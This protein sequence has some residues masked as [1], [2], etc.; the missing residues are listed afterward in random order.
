MSKFSGKRRRRQSSGVAEQ[1]PPTPWP[2]PSQVPAAA[3]DP[4]LPTQRRAVTDPPTND[5]AGG[6]VAGTDPANE[7]HDVVPASLEPE[8]G[9]DSWDEWDES[10]LGERSDLDR[11]C[12]PPRMDQ[13]GD[14]VLMRRNRQDR[15]FDQEDDDV[16]GDERDDEPLIPL[17]STFRPLPVGA[18]RSH[19]AA[20]AAALPDS[21]TVEESPRRMVSR[22]YRLDPFIFDP[23]SIL[24]NRLGWYV[25]D[26]AVGAAP[27]FEALVFGVNGRPDVG[28][29]L[30]V[31]TSVGGWT[32]D[33]AVRELEEVRVRTL[34]DS[35]TAVG[36]DADG[37]TVCV[38]LRQHLD[39][40]AVRLTGSNQFAVAVEIADR[41]AQVIDD[42]L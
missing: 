33:S 40:Y 15:V 26:V 10:S 4:L 25:D 37:D 27:G 21:E 5:G 2:A 13:D 12:E 6:A 1:T 14:M 41:Y 24:V 9:W 11:V 19:G 38:S 42:E 30:I 22:P 18:A 28:I 34:G 23:S 31:P 7:R 32:F 8:Q 20:G 29:Q 16:A 36:F 35:D 39:V 3:I 17:P